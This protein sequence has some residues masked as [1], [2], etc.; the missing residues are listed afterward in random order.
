MA[1]SVHRLGSSGQVRC[2]GLRGSDLPPFAT[3]HSLAAVPIQPINRS[4]QWR[5]AGILISWRVLLR[6]ATGQMK[7]LTQRGDR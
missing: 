4:C 5:R 6:A 2:W 7:R 1:L 3:L